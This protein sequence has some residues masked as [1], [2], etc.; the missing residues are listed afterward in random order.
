MKPVLIIAEAGVN[1][2]GDLTI[3]RQLIDVAAAANADVV[4]FQTYKTENIVSK[5]AKKAAY[6]NKNIDSESDSQ[7]E[8][9]KKLELPISWHIELKKY[10]SDKNI[11]FLST[12]FDLESLDFLASLSPP[13][14]KIPSGEITNK[15][16]LIHIA[17]FQKPIILST[18]MSTIQEIK[19]AV[20]ILNQNGIS[21]NNI[22][23]LHCNTEYP[24]PLKNVNLKAM[25]DIKE[26]IQ[27]EVGYSDHTLG[28]DVALA[29]VAMGA[30][31]IEKHFTLSRSMN[32]P[33]HAASLEPHELKQM[34]N[35]I[36]NIEKAISGDGHKKPSPSELKN[37]DAA[38][39][40][41]HLNT[42]L[43]IGDTIY[44]E[45][46]VIK[47]PGNGISPMEIDNIIGKKVKVKIES[48][49][50]LRWEDLE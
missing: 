9:L 18:G 20:F 2:N 3:A 17:K 34:V 14:F 28:I 12:G 37:K 50:K 4:K 36:R 45:H 49:I 47:R 25:L 40:S 6:Q 27:V 26:K 24:T 39:K 31:V 13:L 8:M 41:L 23:V 48:G 1:H 32:G 22:Q 29:A 10:A 35:G 44:E 38:R 11:V 42:N 46:I 43:N 5:E 30:R 15:P 19:D 7:Y 16:Y 21:K 33:D